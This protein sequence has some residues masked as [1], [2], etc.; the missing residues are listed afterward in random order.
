MS[1]GIKKLGPLARPESTLSVPSLPQNA[2]G[3]A[4]PLPDAALSAA[5]RQALGA[6][7]GQPH[8][9]GSSLKTGQEIA[10]L[11][12]ADKPAAPGKGAPR[13]AHIGPRSGHK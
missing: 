2:P 1:S 6:R 5:F 11:A 7:T 4:P 8:L 12:K 9:P 3:A 13:K 10:K